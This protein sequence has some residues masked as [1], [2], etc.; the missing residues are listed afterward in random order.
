MG[1]LAILTM[2][3]KLISLYLVSTDHIINV[4]KKKIGRI[5]QEL[6]GLAKISLL[7]VNAK[8]SV[9]LTQFSF[10]TKNLLFKHEIS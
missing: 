6:A 7:W 4:T 9:I 5:S 3:Y 2:K 10:I 1:I 8:K